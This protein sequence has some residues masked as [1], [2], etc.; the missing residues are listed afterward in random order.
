MIAY[1]HEVVGGVTGDVILDPANPA[2][3]KVRA[4]NDPHHPAY[5][6]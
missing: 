6:G 3:T 2:N 4:T 1:I 5:T